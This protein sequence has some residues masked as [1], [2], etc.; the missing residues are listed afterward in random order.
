VREK[1][2][3]RQERGTKTVHEVQCGRSGRYRESR[4][5]CGGEMTLILSDK[6]SRKVDENERGWTERESD[7]QR[8]S[9]RSSMGFAISM[10]C[11]HNCC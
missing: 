11:S 7:R 10:S 9:G 2:F 5:Y 1:W 4:Q 6:R 3:N 8:E